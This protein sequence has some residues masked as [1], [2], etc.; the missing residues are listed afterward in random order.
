[1]PQTLNQS[2]I[3]MAEWKYK[4]TSRFFC[5]LSI[6]YQHF[7]MFSGHVIHCTEDEEKGNWV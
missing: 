2:F 5:S 6:L 3:L 1:M 7:E 4:G